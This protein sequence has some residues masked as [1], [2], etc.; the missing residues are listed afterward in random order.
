MY[1]KILEM[2]G[3]ICDTD[4]AKG[5]RHRELERAEVKKSEAAVQR[6]V[7]AIKNFTNPFT[8][9]DK[10]HLFSIAFGAPASSDV[11][12]V[13]LAEAKGRA[14]KEEFLRDR[15]QKKEKSFFDPVKRLMLKTMET[16]NKKVTLTTSKGKVCMRTEYCFS[17]TCKCNMLSQEFLLKH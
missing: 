10:N 1:E 7:K 9:P 6:T 4:V 17:L 3:L 5:G 16:N 2:R 14:A 12:D 13:L 15:M 8:I 11:E